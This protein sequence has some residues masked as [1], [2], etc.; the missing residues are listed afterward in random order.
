MTTMRSLFFLLCLSIAF[1]QAYAGYASP[2]PNHDLRQELEGDPDR[3]IPSFEYFSFAVDGEAWLRALGVQDFY[4]GVG[5][6]LQIRSEVRPHP[7]FTIN[8]RTIPYWG[9]SS[10]GYAEPG[11][12]YS[13][14]GLTGVWPEPMLGAKLKIRIID[15]E[16]Q[17]YGAGLLVQDRETNGA[18]VEW[19]WE[20]HR[21]RLVGDS[22]GALAWDDDMGAAEATLWNGWLG[23]GLLEWTDKDQ[24]HLEKNR[25]PYSYIFSRPE[26]IGPFLFAL[27]A[28]RRGHG[29]GFL[30]ALG[31]SYQGESFS[32]RIKIEGR[33]YRPQT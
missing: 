17:T 12:L 6:W 29:E 21:F 5:A 20:H 9:S 24:A 30:L 3:L 23:A 22:T 11:G 13:L 4:H 28:G 27:E 1:D 32:A 15:I 10:E 19:A 25:S 16:R 26:T 33:Q 18:F 14:I 7:F 8:V 31:S 2:R